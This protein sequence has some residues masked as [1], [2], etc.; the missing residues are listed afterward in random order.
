MNFSNCRGDMFVIGLT[1]GIGTG[2]TQASKLLEEL[3]AAIIDADAVG[4]EAYRPHTEAWGAVVEA[5]GQ[6]VIAPSG[7]VDRKK[8]GGIVFGDPKALRRLNAIMHPR[9]Y[10]MVEERIDNLKQMGRDVVVVEAALLLEA[11]WTALVDEVWSVSASEDRVVRRLARRNNLDQEAVR[12]RIR[13]QMPQSQRTKQA[14]ILIDNSG[15]LADL[16]RRIQQLWNSR[17]PAHQGEHT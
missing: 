10:S 11:G 12:A 2:K 8:L 9:M 6:D 14:D 17:V 7:E 13:S 15:S 3:G 16:R 4:H 1:G 5:F